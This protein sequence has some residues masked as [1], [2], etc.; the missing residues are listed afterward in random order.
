MS[1]YRGRIAPSPTGDLHIGHAHT[2]LTAWSRAG[3][4]GGT[5]VFRM[6]DLDGARCRSEFATSAVEDLYWLGLRWQEGPQPD[7]G[8]PG[9][10]APYRQSERMG[11]YRAAFEQLRAIGL[12]YPCWCSRRDLQRAVSAPHVDEEDEPVY[13]GTCRPR[14]LTEQHA[15]SQ[16]SPSVIP[17]NGP[18]APAWRFRVPQGEV[19]RFVDGSLGPQAYTAGVDFGDFVLLRRDGVPSYQLATVVDDGAMR[20][21]EVVRGQDLLKSTARQILLQRALGF[22]EPAWFHCELL[23]DERGV[24]LAKRNDALSI[25]ALRNRG[26]TPSQV[27]S[28]AVQAAEVR[29]AR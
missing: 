14:A 9:P 2:F 8:E 16:Q 3:E 27:R 18:A 7:G 12:A 17:S 15:I 5:L 4:R 10:F 29:P 21:T 26:L 11:L 6:D 24:R 1:G 23:R 25:G 22:R 19:V 20:I 28:L 13:P